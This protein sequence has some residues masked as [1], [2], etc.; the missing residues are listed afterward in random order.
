MSLSDKLSFLNVCS[1][2]SILW[3]ELK[4][5]IYN[6]KQK[7]YKT[8]FYLSSLIGIVIQG[9][10]LS[11]EVVL[12]WRYFLGWREKSFLNLPC[13]FN[14]S[15]LVCCWNILCV[16]FYVTGKI[17]LL[18]TKSCRTGMIIQWAIQNL[19]TS[20][21]YISYLLFLEPVCEV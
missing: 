16:L 13:V 5:S 3:H 10:M 6:P 21:P 20:S 4:Y 14:I 7:Y 2:I 9:R 12:F 18:L 17:I 11:N 15:L 19:S 1:P 8:S